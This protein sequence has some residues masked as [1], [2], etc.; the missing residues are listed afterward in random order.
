MDVVDPVPDVVPVEDVTPPVEMG[1]ILDVALGAIL[2]VVH[3]VGLPAQLHVIILVN[4]SVM[5]LARGKYSL[6]TT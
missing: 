3:H 6:D 2:L 1:V 4:L 5:V